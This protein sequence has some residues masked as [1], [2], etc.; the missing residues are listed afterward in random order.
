MTFEEW[1]DLPR[2]IP[3][4][5]TYQGWEASCRLAWNAGVKAEREACAKLCETQNETGAHIRCTTAIRK[6]TIK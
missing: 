4:P 2:S 1:W 6:R 5:D 3:T